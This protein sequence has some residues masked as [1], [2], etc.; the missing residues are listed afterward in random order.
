MNT[1]RDLDTSRLSDEQLTLRGLDTSRFSD[2][3]LAFVRDTLVRH[4]NVR[5]T[6]VIMHKPAWKTPTPAFAK[7]QAMLGSRRYTVFAGHLHYF[8]HDLLDGR[9]YIN[10]GMTG[11][12]RHQVGP[13]A[14][15]HAMLVTLGPTG[16]FYANPAGPPLYANIRLNGL[17]DVAGNTG[18]V[19][20]LFARVSFLH[21][22]QRE[23]G[24]SDGSCRREGGPGRR[25]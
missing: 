5:W 1:L 23:V 15:D 9:D 19:R 3:Q 7:I 8:T 20:A 24:K 12:I 22:L 4:A 25:R 14:L 21:A 13:G 10:M 6:F 18:Q 17:M 16:P 2:K 11:G